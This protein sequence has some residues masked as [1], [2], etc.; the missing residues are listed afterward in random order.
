MNFST[1][2]PLEQYNMNW[3][4]QVSRKVDIILIMHFRELLHWWMAIF[5]EWY[6]LVYTLSMMKIWCIASQSVAWEPSANE[7]RNFELQLGKRRNQ[8]Q[9]QQGNS[10]ILLFHSWPEVCFKV[11]SMLSS[12]PSIHSS[13]LINS[14]DATKVRSQRGQDHLPS[15]YWYVATRNEKY[16]DDLYCLLGGELAA[17]S[18]LG[19]ATHDYNSMTTSVIEQ[20][21]CYYS[22]QDRSSWSFS[23]EGGRRHYEEHQGLEGSSCHYSVDHPKPSSSSCCCSFRFFSCHQGS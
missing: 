13:I 14:L 2:D 1:N 12:N 15:R 22:S 3:K 18:A 9:W 7:K 8:G 19:N 10:E 23:Q 17:S 20:P 21:L 11:A 16:M 5:A 4:N 6:V